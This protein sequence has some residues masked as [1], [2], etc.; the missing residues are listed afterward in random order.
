MERDLLAAGAARVAVMAELSRS[1][2]VVVSQIGVTSARRPSQLA[3]IAAVKA[4]AATTSVQSLLPG[5]IASRGSMSTIS[6]ARDPSIAMS[7]ATVAVP[8]ASSAPRV[9]AAPPIVSTRRGAEPRA[10]AGWG[11]PGCSP[12]SRGSAGHH[13]NR[14]ASASRGSRGSANAAAGSRGP[15]KTSWICSRVTPRLTQ[16]SARL[17]KFS[18]MSRWSRS[19]ALT[20]ALPRRGQW[21]AANTM[22]ASAATR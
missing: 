3:L 21:C 15:A 10:T 19:T 2:I 13:R 6:A 9:V 14:R 5:T 18:C 4:S 17:L 22:R 16:C 7:P 1:R 12:G 11:W 20:R 8:S